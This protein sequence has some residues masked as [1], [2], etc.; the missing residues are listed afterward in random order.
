MDCTKNIIGYKDCNKAF[1]YYLDDYGISLNS[2]SK[3]NDD[4][5]TNAK[6]MLDTIISQSWKETFNDITFDGMQANKI[7]N[8]VTYGMSESVNEFTGT[9]TVTL[10]KDDD[11][12][13]GEFYLSSL[14]F[15]VK[16]GGETTVQLIQGTTTTELYSDTPSDGD[17]VT[18]NINSFVSDVFKL[19]IITEGESYKNK[20]SNEC[21]CEGVQWYTYSDDYNDYPFVFPFQVRCSKEVHL[22]K[23]VDLIA[24]I[25]INKILGKYWFKVYT[26]DVF[27][28][29]V[30]SSADKVIP[31]MVY[32]DSD[33]RS[34]VD[35]E[36]QGKAE[37]QYQILLNK[38]NIP[39][40]TCKCCMECK[41]SGWGYVGQKP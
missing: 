19:R 4:K 21:R 30:N 35:S 8:D 34:I 29:Y 22:C 5:F 37:G 24:P 14:T 26:T 36:G 25:V 15:Y 32:Y 13:L 41:T 31:L 28:N 3:V 16:T 11:C 39:K 33:Y 27:S 23:Y 6:A 17:A 9:K 1:R 20:A 38:L 40:P 10:T 2:A 7:L 18:I 12:E